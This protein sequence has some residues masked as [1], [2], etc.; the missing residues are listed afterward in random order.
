MWENVHDWEHLPHL[1]EGSFDLCELI[2]AGDWGWR[3]YS[4]ADQRNTIELVV[5]DEHS[6]VSRTYRD[7]QQNAEIWTT[8]TPREN[9]TEIRV[10]FDIPG[11]PEDKVE[12]L[13]KG[14]LGLYE[15]LWDEDEAMMIER[16]RRLTEARSRDR[17]VELELIASTRFQLGGREYELTETDGEWSAIPVVCP[18]LL[19]PLSA[20]NVEAGTIRCP[21]H[22][23]VFDLESGNCI[24]PAAATCR[25][26]PKPE[27]DVHDDKIIATMPD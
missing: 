12:A 5:R 11:I 13:G 2:E 27:L 22:G 17:Q 1:H 23:Y 21:W 3:V 7:G 19:G 14:M 8:L 15:R 4:S 24:K 6:Y 10:E 16:T 25:L 9:S 20:E 26:P 18:H